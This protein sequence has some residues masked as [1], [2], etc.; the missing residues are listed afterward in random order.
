MVVKTASA[1]LPAP[2]PGSGSGPASDQQDL[3][4]VPGGAGFLVTGALGGGTGQI[5]RT[6]DHGASWQ[7]VWSRP[8]AAL[9]WVG[10]AGAD[11]LAS[12]TYAA[13][14]GDP[15]AASPL[16]LRSSD[17][18]GTWT[19][20]TPSLP[21]PPGLPAGETDHPGLDWQ[22][23]R[24]EF[25]STGV[26]L[27][28]TDANDGGATLSH[29]ILRSTDGGRSWSEISLPGGRPDGGLAFTDPLH[30][31][32]TGTVTP[33][34]TAG[35]CTSQMWST[36]D[37]G[38]SWQAVPGTCVGWDLDTVTFSDPSHGFAAGGNFSKYGLFPQRA[39]LVST[40]G[41]VHWSQAYAAGGNAS[42]GG[43][44][45]GGPFVAVHFIDPRT[46]Y[47]LVGGCTMGANG[48]CGGALWWT[49]DGGRDW[50]RGSASGLRLAVDGA[51]DV[52]VVGGGLAGASVMWRSADGA[53][54][55][56]PVA[57]PA[58]IG[59]L[60]LLGG[61]GHLWIDS[62]A[63]QFISTDGAVSWTVLPAAAQVAENGGRA[64]VAAVGSSGLVAI[65]G[66]GAQ[67]VWISHDGG[68]SGTTTAVPGLGRMGA[69]ALAFAD[70]RHGLALGQG[71]VCA[72]GA[73]G[74]GR[75]APPFTASPAAVVATDDGGGSWG[76]TTTLNLSFAGLGYG[77]TVAVAT[78]TG[79]GPTPPCPYD[80]AT[81]TDGG[82]HWRT[83]SVPPQYRCGSPSAAGDTAVLVCPDYSS[84]TP[85]TTILVSRDAARTWTAYRLTGPGQ[86]AGVVAT[87]SG[88]LWAYGPPGTLW[89]STDG[90]AHWT[91]LVPDLPVAR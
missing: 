52:W 72:K 89:R 58:S 84:A 85:T 90:A 74:P 4:F 78:G 51:G 83:W 49:S 17:G 86:I 69:V 73:A 60:S 15:N 62:A 38:S 59:V 35:A 55:W 61:G 50:S 57:D 33:P 79:P 18:G 42:G 64:T 32:A 23:L 63:G 76:S 8:G 22:Q 43:P 39:V 1:S 37:G 77:A 31:F 9:Y 65:G 24:L 14:G 82:A 41:G 27:A 54:T 26:G 88:Q 19:S 47:A 46:G 2:P 81:S 80:V 20:L 44:D 3:A 6:T 13:P 48:P 87:G 29:Q 70:D 7:T 45:D 5:Q 10:T 25:P 91:A 71:A 53:R 36:E 56:T 12:G 11:V 40:D 75:S 28:V 34:A 21:P 67:Q 30:G 16:L 68:R 66:L